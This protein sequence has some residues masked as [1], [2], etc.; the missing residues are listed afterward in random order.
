[1]STSVVQWT[2]PATMGY[3]LKALLVNLLARASMQMFTLSMKI[4][5]PHKRGSSK[6]SKG[7][8]TSTT[9]T[10]T[11]LHST[12]TFLPVE[13]WIKVS[14]WS[15]I[16]LIYSFPALVRKETQLDFFEIHFDTSTYDKVDRDIKVTIEAQPGQ[17]DNKKTHWPVTRLIV[18]SRWPWKLSW[19]LLEAPWDFLLASP[20]S[21]A[22]K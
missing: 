22:L 18:I 9:L 17:K 5:R 15:K 20:S 3:Q 12:L 19:D 13:V 1:M 11:R 4:Q 10:K 14:E 6:N 7:W 8:L 16:N 21:V 2:I